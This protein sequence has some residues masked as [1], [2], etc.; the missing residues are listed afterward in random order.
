M[1]LWL[2]ART[3]RQGEANKS[4]MIT[5]FIN[6]RL[7]DGTGRDPQPGSTVAVEGKRIIAVGQ[8]AEVSVPPDAKVIDLQGKTLM[9][10]LIDCHAEVAAAGYTL[11]TLLHTPMS[12]V[13]FETARRLRVALDMGITTLRDAGPVDIGY[14]QAIEKGL[15]A[16]PRLHLTVFGITQSGGHADVTTP[17]GAMID[18]RHRPMAYRIA[19]GADEIR[20]TARQAIREGA[21][22][23]KLCTSGSWIHMPHDSPYCIHFTEQ[24]I[25]AAAEIAHGAGKKLVCH[26]EGAPGVKNALRAGADAIEHASYADDECFEL[27]AEKGVYLIPALLAPYTFLELAC[28]V[29]ISQD[30][31]DNCR[32]QLEHHHKVFAQAVRAGV[33][34]ALGEDQGYEINNHRELVLMVDAGMIPIEAI[35]AGT[36]HAAECL[37]LENITGTLESGKA[38]DLLVVD[39]DPL[40]D[41]AILQQ[42]DKLVLVMSEGKI[43]R[44]TLA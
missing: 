31:A 6:A 8:N 39:G 17:S 22:S 10:G 44:N 26:A 24:E 2:N 14:R 27:M 18:F 29:P 7:L 12:Y 21:D 4:V 40:A 32:R 34:I 41:I 9:P 43:V 3:F 42:N 13:H 19:D 20:R 38:A 16:G 33:K 35:V 5:A 11:T 23:I 37:G 36:R 25:Y 30:V 15:I 1:S 28:Q